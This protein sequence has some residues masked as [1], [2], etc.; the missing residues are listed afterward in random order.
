[1]ACY[2]MHLTFAKI[3][4]Q[5]LKM[6]EKDFL[7]GS[8]AADVCK[9]EFY[10]KRI[11]H[12]GNEHIKVQLDKF[13]EKYKEKLDVPFVMGY[14]VHIYLDYVFFERFLENYFEILEG[15]YYSDM[16]SVFR[17]RK[18][19][20]IITA[21]ELYGERFYNT[22]TNINRKLVE[23][24]NLPANFEITDEDIQRYNIIDEYDINNLLNINNEI[25]RF[26]NSDEYIA[27]NDDIY[28]IEEFEE[29][30]YKYSNEFINKYDNLI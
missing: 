2:S 22:Y 17:E 11:T 27:D 25:E 19:G 4:N 21:R 29:F 16:T 28:T 30:M 13:L 10:T 3:V 7:I 5:R 26:I 23:K 9:K 24:Y 6:D 12:F 15:N 14:F 1:M 20:D 8:L 18:T